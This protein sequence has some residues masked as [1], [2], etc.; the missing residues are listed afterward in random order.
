MPFL[1]EPHLR[2]GK[3]ADQWFLSSPLIYRSDR[4]DFTIQV[5]TGFETDLASIPRLF[6]RLIPRGGKHRLPS[7]V[8]DFLYLCG[9]DI[10]GEKFTR[11]E[12]DLIFLD[13]M[14]EC[15][16]SWLT[17][18]TMYRAVRVGGWASW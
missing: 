2:I 1:V 14:A 3:E 11:K 8:H 16:V 13:A 18:H 15:G 6:R 4:F 7:I 12:C 5:P 10:S 17:R 9:G